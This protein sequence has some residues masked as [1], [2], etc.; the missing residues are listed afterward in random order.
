MRVLH[1]PGS[2]NYCSGFLAA[3][4]TLEG[5]EP[6]GQILLMSTRN[7]FNAFFQ[8]QSHIFITLFFSNYEQIN[9]KL[10]CLAQHLFITVKSGTWTE[11]GVTPDSVCGNDSL[12]LRGRG[13]FFLCEH[14]SHLPDVLLCWPTS[15]ACEQL[16]SDNVIT[17]V[18]ELR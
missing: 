9:I 18:T 1:A 14:I 10:I 13:G 5:P 16:A 17:V 12:F 6:D 11:I 3:V 8:Y 2:C 15:L 4:N 7:C